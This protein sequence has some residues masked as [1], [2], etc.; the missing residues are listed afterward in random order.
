MLEDD[1]RISLL[2]AFLK[3]WVF[4]SFIFLLMKHKPRLV[5]WFPINT[6]LSRGPRKFV[7]M[8]HELIHFFYIWHSFCSNITVVGRY[9]GRIAQA[10]VKKKILYEW[11][12]NFK[13]SKSQIFSISVQ[14]EHI[15]QISFWFHFYEYGVTFI[16]IWVYLYMYILYKC[17]IC[18][19][20]LFRIFKNEILFK[21]SP[22]LNCSLNST[23]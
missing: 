23:V 19:F 8:F 2:S 1:W 17:Y 3:L 15:L 9:V 16:Y 7:Y 11:F 10:S 5:D 18:I 6:L 14:I 12:I 21:K 4:L 13:I 22:N 20:E